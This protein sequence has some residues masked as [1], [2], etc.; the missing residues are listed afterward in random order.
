VNVLIECAYFDPASIR[1]TSRKL[2]LQTDASDRFERRVDYEGQLRAQARTIALITEIAGGAATEDAIDIY[3]QPIKPP[4]VALR[5]PRVRAL[6]GLDVPTQ[7][8][9]RILASLGFKSGGDPAT[10]GNGGKIAENSPISPGGEPSEFVVPTWRADVTVEEDLV[11]EVARHFGYEKIEDALPASNTV[12]EYRAHESRRRAARRA[13]ADS[14]FDEAI[15]FSFIDA[16]QDD[17]FELSPDLV[18][19]AG[20]GV[21]ANFVSLANP[22]IEGASRMRAT[23]LPGLLAAVR[24]N[25]NHGS[26]D[27][28]LFEMGRVFAAASEGEARPTERESCGLVATGGA[29]EAGRAAAPRELDFYDL[30]GALEA[31]AD[32]MKLPPLEFSAARARHLREGQSAQVSL[33]G[34][35]VGWIGRL[36]DEIAATYKFRQPVYVAEVSMTALLATDE[37]PARYAPLARFP[38]VVRD[39]SLVVDRR[40][41]F[42]EMRRAAL[43]MKLE[44]VRDVEL[45]YV[46]EGERVPEGKRSVTLRVEYRSDER[47]LRDEEA[48]ALH[49]QIV[50]ALEK[51]LGAQLR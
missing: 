40:A 11:E 41:T 21:E 48:D 32:A 28:R 44:N 39:A 12:G 29:T 37:L 10:G 9:T 19:G 31:A 23:L 38:G 25:F 20:E 3:P 51:K 14:G 15:S 33:G 49:K 13:L 47:T 2:G 30:K 17:R 35:A 36:S 16:V 1:R 22:I 34:R 26:R 24:H 46:Y 8:A 42:A 43:D 18:A 7:E 27:V 45:V 5:F 4:T 6:T 50:D